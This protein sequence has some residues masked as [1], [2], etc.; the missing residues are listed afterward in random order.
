MYE[1]RVRSCHWSK[2]VFDLPSVPSDLI[3]LS[4]VSGKIVLDSSGIITCAIS[5][6]RDGVI[7]STGC[8]WDKTL[9]D[10]PSVPSDL[11]LLSFVSHKVVL[12]SSS[13][14]TCAISYRRDGV[15]SC[16]GE[17]DQSTE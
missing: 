3:L 11:I 12:D 8:Q 14:L 2:R 10:L 15:I 1:E 6:Q 7:L 5:Y 17:V 13:M 16:A 9:F 4:F